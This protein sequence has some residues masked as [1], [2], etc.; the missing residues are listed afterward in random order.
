MLGR[1]KIFREASR[2]WEIV[3]QNFMQDRILS[4]SFEEGENLLDRKIYLSIRRV[5]YGPSCRNLFETDFRMINGVL[6]STDHIG[7]SMRA[8]VRVSSFFHAIPTVFTTKCASKGD[9]V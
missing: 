6:A 3:L 5:N 9:K 4:G 2:V 1:K 7:N 8:T